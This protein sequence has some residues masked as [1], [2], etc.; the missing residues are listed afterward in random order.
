MIAL[1]DFAVWIKN[2]LDQ[3]I[4]RRARADRCQVR[5]D[6]SPNAANRMATDTTEFGPAENPLS[7]RRVA[8]GRHRRH[9]LLNLRGRQR[10]LGVFE[11]GAV[12]ERQHQ[13][14]FI[15]PAFPRDAKSCLRRRRGKTAR[16]QSASKRGGCPFDVEQRAPEFQR[17]GFIWRRLENGHRQRRG[18]VQIERGQ[19]QRGFLANLQRLVRAAQRQQSIDGARPADFA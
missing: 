10:Q 1:L 15:A 6:F 11:P 2:R 5:P 4:H 8:L 14:R 18:C 12:R 7:A 9:D 3:V 17:V 13:F 16:G 19:R